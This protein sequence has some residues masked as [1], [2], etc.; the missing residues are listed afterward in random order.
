MIIK[1]R[2][3]LNHNVVQ[4]IINL[5]T[6]WSLF[7]DNIQVLAFEKDADLGFDIVS[8]IVIS[9]F[10][11]ET[12]LNVLTK[13]NYFLGFYFYMD[14]VATLTMLMDVQM[15]SNAIFYRFALFSAPETRKTRLNWR[16]LAGLPDWSRKRN[17]FESTKK[18][19]KSFRHGAL[20]E[21]T[22]K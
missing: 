15:I 5:L 1:L 21:W 22:M 20:L 18:A 8:Y 2:E 6:A 9:V 3:F 4:I 7:A 12:C 19:F 11:T 16:R 17:S 10:V 14:V 13:E